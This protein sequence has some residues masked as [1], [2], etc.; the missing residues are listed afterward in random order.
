V[1]RPEAAAA[2]TVWDR[3]LAHAAAA[4]VFVVEAARGLPGG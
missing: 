1:T 3:Y 4:V 2:V